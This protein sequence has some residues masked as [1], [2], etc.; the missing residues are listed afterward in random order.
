MYISTL[1]TSK[2]PRNKLKRWIVSSAEE[3]MKDE[4]EERTTFVQKF[5]NIP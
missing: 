3:R 2:L 1:K 4:L 5:G